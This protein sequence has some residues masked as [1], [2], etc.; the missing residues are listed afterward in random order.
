MNDMSSRADPVGSSSPNSKVA[1]SLAESRE[2]VPA[3]IAVPS[4]LTD[5][6]RIPR[7]MAFSVML[8]VGSQ[9]LDVHRLV[10]GERER[11]EVGL[12]S[13]PVPPGRHVLR[14]CNSV[15]RR[16]KAIPLRKVV[17]NNAGYDFTTSCGKDLPD[18]DVFPAQLVSARRSASTLAVRPAD[19][20]GC[21]LYNMHRFPPVPSTPSARSGERLTCPH[22]PCLRRFGTPT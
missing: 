10:P 22:R 20:V 4:T 15:G 13:Q 16:H 1:V 6:P 19:G 9:N 3:A 8:D 12:Q 5:A 21:C 14:Q 18:R 7:S 17:E 11:V 2:I